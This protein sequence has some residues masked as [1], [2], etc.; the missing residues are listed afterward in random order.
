MSTILEFLDGTNILIIVVGFGIAWGFR[1]IKTA[2]KGTA[3]E[4]ELGELIEVSIRAGKDGK[5]TLKEGR[6]IGKEG[7]D[8][9]VALKAFIAAKKDNEAD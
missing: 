2:I 3:L 9:L 1:R 4:A 8:S 6:A 5:I 7:K